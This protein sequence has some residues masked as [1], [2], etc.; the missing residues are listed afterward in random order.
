[1][2]IYEAAVEMQAQEKRKRGQKQKETSGS[3]IE[4]ARPPAL[5]PTRELLKGTRDLCSKS[6]S[7][8]RFSQHETTRSCIDN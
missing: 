6:A 2:K 4:R 7:F 5:P 1:M 8:L 3:A